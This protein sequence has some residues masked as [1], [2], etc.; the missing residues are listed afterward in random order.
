MRFEMLHPSENAEATYGFDPF[1]LFFVEVMKGSI[2]VEQCDAL[3]ADGRLEGVL[4]VL[5]RHGFL[6]DMDVVLA[7]D[8]L[9]HTR[10]W[11]RIEDLGVRRAAEVLDGLRRA[12]DEP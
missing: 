2:V 3:H 10:D 5:V 12:A 4:R 8:A 11:S 7:H 9:A 6:D 1:L